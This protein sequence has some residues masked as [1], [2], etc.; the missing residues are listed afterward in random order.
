L[1]G[2]GVLRDGEPVPLCAWQSRKARDLLKLL[3][4]RRG[5]PVPREC[6]LEA[7]WPEEDPRRSSCR[8]S[9]ALSTL[10]SVLDPEHRFAPDHYVVGARDAISLRMSAVELDLGAFVARAEEGLALVRAGRGQAGLASL[11]AAE[12]AYGGDFLEE[13]LFEDWAAGPREEAR[14][15]YL[16]V[17]RALVELA[18]GRGDHDGACRYSLRIL[19][20]DPYDERAHLALVSARVSARAHGEARRAYRRYADRMAEIGVEPAPYP[21]PRPTLAATGKPAPAAAVGYA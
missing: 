15:V 11:E 6:L 17:A 21:H 5:R 9:V 19:E 20:R 13:D 16:T 18:A 12:R 4:A 3:V 1:G 10:R 8:L 7:L 2:F 14:A